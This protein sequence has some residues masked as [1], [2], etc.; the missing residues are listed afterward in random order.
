MAK[1]VVEVV[2]ATCV[3]VEV[4]AH[5]EEEAQ[6]LAY[7]RQIPL[8]LLNGTMILILCIEMMKRRNNPP[9]FLSIM[10]VH[11]ISQNLNLTKPYSY[12]IIYSRSEGK[13]E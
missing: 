9:F 7:K 2:M 3:A 5:N 10:N 12:S 4:E 8:M 11:S 1:Y 6:E 13:H